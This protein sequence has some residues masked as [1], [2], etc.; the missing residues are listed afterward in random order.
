MSPAQII[1][2]IVSITGLIS[3]VIAAYHAFGAKKAAQSTA[4]QPPV[5]LPGVPQSSP[6]PRP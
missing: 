4:A 3:A 1:Q 5:I 6:P 2:L